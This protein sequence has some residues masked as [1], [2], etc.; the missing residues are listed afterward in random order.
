[1]SGS[2]G[3]AVLKWR[4]IGWTGQGEPQHDNKAR[5][6][7]PDF[8]VD[9][10]RELWRSSRPRSWAWKLTATSSMSSSDSTVPINSQIDADCLMIRVKC[11]FVQILSGYYW[12]I[13]WLRFLSGGRSR[14]AFWKASVSSKMSRKLSKYSWYRWWRCGSFESRWAKPAVCPA[15]A[16]ITP[17]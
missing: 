7:S 9:R 8:S 10:R 1:M 12:E 6:R 13:T 4:G 16:I 15:P 2:Q 5:R 3:P 11:G 17:I 14:T